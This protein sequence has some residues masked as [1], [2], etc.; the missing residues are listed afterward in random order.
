MFS[1]FYK[2]EFRNKEKSGFVK[3]DIDGEEVNFEELKHTLKKDLES[4]Y[5][6]EKIIRI[7]EQEYHKLKRG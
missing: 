4:E 1:L 6:E 3:I 7:S 5:P 2:V